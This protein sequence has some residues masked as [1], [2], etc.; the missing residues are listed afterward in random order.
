MEE[1]P[2]SGNSLEVVAKRC[3]GDVPGAVELPGQIFAYV[4]R[5]EF[6][7]EGRWGLFTFGMAGLVVRQ[8][9][10]RGGHRECWL[11]PRS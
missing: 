3:R 2:G 11:S 4:G 6:V 9:R 5:P 10:M 1:S 7:R 8:L